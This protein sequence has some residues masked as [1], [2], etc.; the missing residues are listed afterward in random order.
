MAC[1]VVGTLN[2]T[3]AETA[4]ENLASSRGCIVAVHLQSHVLKTFALTRA[5]LSSI[6]TRSH[7]LFAHSGQDLVLVTRSYN[8]RAHSV[9]FWS[10]VL[11]GRTASEVICYGAA[12]SAASDRLDVPPPPL[13]LPPLYPTAAAITHHRRYIPPPPRRWALINSATTDLTRRRR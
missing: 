1:V 10:P 11:R 7:S 4:M 13:L 12:A 5:A 3:F 8:L 9:Q 6:V 2:E